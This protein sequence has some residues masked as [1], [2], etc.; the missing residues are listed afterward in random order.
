MVAFPFYA[1]KVVH[2]QI[3]R[4]KSL[5]RILPFHTVVLIDLFAYKRIVNLIVQLNII[6]AYSYY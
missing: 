3:D 5:M 4:S 1:Y 6:I 2:S